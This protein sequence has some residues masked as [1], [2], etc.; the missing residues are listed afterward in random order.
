M[1]KENY[2]F[3]IQFITFIKDCICKYAINIMYDGSNEYGELVILYDEDI[4]CNS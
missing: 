1:F 2:K 4:S 3:T